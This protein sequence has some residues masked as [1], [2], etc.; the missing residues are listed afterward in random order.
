MRPRAVQYP[1]KIAGG[2]AIPPALFVSA[3]MISGTG[4]AFAGRISPRLLF[5]KGFLR[6]AARKLFFCRFCGFL[7]FHV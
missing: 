4:C 1:C 3:G 2:N 6:R 5:Q 7:P